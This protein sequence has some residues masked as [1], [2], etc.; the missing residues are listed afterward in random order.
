MKIKHSKTGK[1]IKVPKHLET[2]VRQ[3]ISSGTDPMSVM[4]EGGVFNAPKFGVEM[5]VPRALYPTNNKNLV[6]HRNGGLVKYEDGNYV[7]DPITNFS[8]NQAY[9]GLMYNNDPLYDPNFHY[10]PP[11]NTDN[12]SNAVASSN[13][14]DPF[15]VVSA[16][17][18]TGFVDP[19]NLEKMQFAKMQSNPQAF[20]LGYV[21]EPLLED[22]TP[23]NTNNIA[24]VVT[25]T[26]QPRSLIGKPTRT[27]VPPDKL[28][29]KLNVMPRS[30]KGG[31]ADFEED[32]EMSYAPY[33]LATN[34]AQALIQNQN[35]NKTN[36]P[37][38]FNPIGLT[39]GVT[40]NRYDLS[41]QRQ[42]IDADTAA[43]NIGIRLGGGS[44][45]TQA[46]NL[47]KMRNLQMQKKGESFQNEANMNTQ[48]MNEYN[49]TK[50]L[51]ANEAVKA[52][53]SIDQANREALY[54]YNLWKTGAKNAVTA[55]TAKSV[56]NI[57]NNLTAYKNQ[58]ES[59]KAYANRLEGKRV[60]ED[61]E[62]GI[63]GTAGANEGKKEN[64]KY[65]GMIKSSPKRS[66]KRKAG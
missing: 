41:S 34:F 39:A 29:P 40:P 21:P 42:A 60:K 56:A 52:N 18:T 1:T 59:W 48:T 64:N 26:I 7:G 44:Y 49:K 65:G 46:G 3:A 20:Q 24:P 12:R 8:N 16:N 31:K 11:L 10:N 37:T 22:N 57:F 38:P 61:T 50:A 23:I 17:N 19:N 63:P 58:K 2:S 66:L 35:I 33:A 36:A 4:A 55:D 53:A 30:N 5:N 32:S 14:F 6:M 62:Q 9:R 13:M 45:S 15:N 54:N 47:Q 27:M 51:T 43:A 28:G 25:N